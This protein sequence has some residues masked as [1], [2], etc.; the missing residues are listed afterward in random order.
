MVGKI[1]DLGQ[2]Q[3]TN[4][5]KRGYLMTSSVGIF[6]GSGGSVQFQKFWP[7]M[8]ARLE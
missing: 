5:R 3:R 7:Q 1:R 2:A 6:G 4:G 8:K